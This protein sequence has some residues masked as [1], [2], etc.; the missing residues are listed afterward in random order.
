MDNTFIID[1]TQED[2]DAGLPKDPCQCPIALALYRAL[3]KTVNK[4]LF[5]VTNMS[6][7]HID[8]WGN[9]TQAWLPMSAFNF[10]NRFDEGKEVKPFTFEI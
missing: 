7:R 9:V 8:E 10:I 1:V 6:I 5:E 4:Y 3:D 2:I